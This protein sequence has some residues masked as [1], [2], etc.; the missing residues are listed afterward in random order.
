MAVS[1]TCSLTEP[2]NTK[3]LLFSTNSA[4]LINF[5]VGISFCFLYIFYIILYIIY[6]IYKAKLK[7]ELPPSR[8]KTVF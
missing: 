1:E 4:I 3:K 7:N 2:L 6:I 8:R 5:S